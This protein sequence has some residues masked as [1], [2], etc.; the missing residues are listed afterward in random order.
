MRS[1]GGR[2]G[3][4]LVAE[5]GRAER[6][7][8]GC[9][10]ESILLS[11]RALL[12]AKHSFIIYDSVHSEARDHLYDKLD[13]HCVRHGDSDSSHISVMM[14]TQMVPWSSL[15]MVMNDEILDYKIIWSGKVTRLLVVVIS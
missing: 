5:K 9:G 4:L 10:G 1:A 14:P 6:V 13:I 11:R 2:S 3:D 12:N 7:I 15:T 8:F